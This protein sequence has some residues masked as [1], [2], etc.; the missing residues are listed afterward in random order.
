MNRL[1]CTS[2]ALC[3]ACGG[4]AANAQQPDTT[5]YTPKTEVRFGFVSTSVK[6]AVSL[7]GDTV[8][9]AGASVQGVEFQVWA[10]TGGGL[11]ARYDVGTL[12]GGSSL[13]AA[14]KFESLDGRVLLGVP[15]FALVP[16]F[17]MRAVTWNGE[18]RRFNLAMLGLEV[19]RRFGGAGFHVRGGGMYIRAPWK[20]KAD[21]LITSGV[22]AHTSMVYAPPR[23]PLYVSLGY[24]REVM[25]HK[26]ESVVARREENSGIVFSV[27]LQTGMPER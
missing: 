4:T 25:A 26:R 1:R 6:R 16:G 2:L 27:G 22:E 7:G 17:L 11:R 5:L 9:S 14:G 21:S 3:L 19:G 8:T 24:R 12:P 18:V 23:L 10:P 20:G 15:G 13:A